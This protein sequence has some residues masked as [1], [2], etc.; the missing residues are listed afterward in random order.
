MMQSPK[1][2]L[3]ESMPGSPMEFVVP[4]EDE[5][6]NHASGQ[7]MDID[8]DF[9]SAADYDPTA[10]MQEERL[11]HDKRL[12]KED[13]VSEMKADQQAVEQA[14]RG[15]ESTR[16]MEA[17]LGRAVYVAGENW[18]KICDPGAEGIVAIV[19]G[20]AQGSSASS[21]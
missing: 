13:E 4:N 15:C 11:R 7:V 6:S 16:G 3:M 9:Q 8:G 21:G 10:D 1:T 14:K 5:L 2:P 20:L 19:S 17:S 18:G 12:F